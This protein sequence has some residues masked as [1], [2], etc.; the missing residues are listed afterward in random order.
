[1]IDRPDENA[2]LT[3]LTRKNSAEEKSSIVKF[4]MWAHSEGIHSVD[5]EGASARLRRMEGSDLFVVMYKHWIER[6]LGHPIATLD[7]MS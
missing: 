4:I 1:M 6:E 3:K 5:P 7:M 2:A